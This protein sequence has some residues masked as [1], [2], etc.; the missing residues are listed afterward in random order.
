MKG[1]WQIISNDLKCKIKLKR[2]RGST[3]SEI[4]T[5]QNIQSKAIHKF[6]IK[7]T[8]T[9]C[10]VTFYQRDNTGIIK[11]ELNQEEFKINKNACTSCNFILEL[12]YL[13][14]NPNNQ[15]K[16]ELCL[17]FMTNIVDDGNPYIL[18]GGSVIYY[19]NICFK[20]YLSLLDR[21][22]HVK[23]H[24]FYEIKNEM[25]FPCQDSIL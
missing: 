5:Y 17:N 24:N 18:K 10:N 22:N 2:L 15:R 11:L 14:I 6:K 3:E 20:S 7:K 16:S 1:D 23:S 12:D 4:G 8:C 13:D 19:C 21:S 9:L 25:Q